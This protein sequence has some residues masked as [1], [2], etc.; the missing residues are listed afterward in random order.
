MNTDFDQVN[1]DLL[2]KNE[3]V[4]ALVHLTG[5][6]AERWR[7][8]SIRELRVELAS[9]WQTTKEAKAKVE[10]TQKFQPAQPPA[11]GALDTAALDVLVAR[12][13]HAVEEKLI[14]RLRIVTGEDGEP[15]AQAQDIEAL[16]QKADLAVP[17]VDPTY[18]QPYQDYTA[19]LEAKSRA[20]LRP[21]NVALWGPTGAG[22][23]TFAIQFAA[24]Y[25]RPLYVLNV[26]EVTEAEQLLG[27]M[28]AKDGSTYWEPSLLWQ[29]VQVPFAV[30]L[31]DELNRGGNA[32]VVNALFEV[33][34][35]RR[36]LGGA[37]VAPGVIFFATLNEGVEYT[38]TDELDA[39]IGDRFAEGAYI[40]YSPDEVN[41]LV[42]RHGCDVEVAEGVVRLANT[43][44]GKYP[45]SLRILGSCVEE[46]KFGAP[47]QEALLHTFGRR[48]PA[49]VLA[50]A[51]SAALPDVDFSGYIP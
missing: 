33:L 40:D 21:R 38:G 34:D 1:I 4:D 8:E 50:Q 15:T 18:R 51:C 30:I 29:A 41:V 5:I 47:M 11:A 37:P 23:T 27:Q 28:R 13:T 49:K 10:R 2:T 45:I 3:L 48:V 24:Q 26:G 19:R 39:A 25:Q 46:H 6:S 35:D 16:T 9:A 7:Q 17:E 44:R 12:A 43:L 14:S 20:T 42:A 31:L 36:T 32:K 22:K